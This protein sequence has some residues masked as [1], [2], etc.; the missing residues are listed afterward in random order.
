MIRNN[1][2]EDYI[3][4]AALLRT[5]SSE[6]SFQLNYVNITYKS[7]TFFTFIRGLVVVLKAERNIDKT[8]TI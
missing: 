2:R 5:I 7:T 4:I 3:I 6:R 1:L 8:L